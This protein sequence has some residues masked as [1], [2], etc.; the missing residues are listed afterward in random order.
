MATQ[1]KTKKPVSH[2]LFWTLIKETPGYKDAYK[3]VIKEGLVNQHSGGKTCSL[4]EM[5]RKY[6]AEYSN[7]LEA[8]KGNAEQRLARYEEARDKAAKRVIAAICTWLDKIGYKFETRNDKIR[9]VLSIACR[10]ANCA[11]FNAIPESK[12]VAIYN[13]YCNKNSV[14]IE[15]PAL[16]YTIS[17]N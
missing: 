8:M 5:Y 9:Y 16:D 2:A 11:N 13:L 1:K 14:N 3:D 4:S 17:K 10:A 15:Y 6:P 7:M 12:L